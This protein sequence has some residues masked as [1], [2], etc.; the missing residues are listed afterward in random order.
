MNGLTVDVNIAAGTDLFGKS[1][2][3]LQHDMAVKPNEID[4]YLKYVADYSAAYGPG[5]DSG[6]YLVIHTEV[7][8]VEDVTITAEV[9][10]GKTGPVIVDPSDG[11]LISWIENSSKKIKLTASKT[12]YPDVTKV[13]WL[14][15]LILE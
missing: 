10:G 12:G 5:M 2:T 3:D 4:G 15:S 7:P 14:N 6:H 13:F 11:I 8:D 1:V 9:I